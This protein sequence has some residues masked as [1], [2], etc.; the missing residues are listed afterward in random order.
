VILNRH[1][2]LLALLEATR[3]AAL[4]ARLQ[5]QVAQ[6]GFTRSIILGRAAQEKLF[7]QRIVELNPALTKAAGELLSATNAESARFAGILL[8]LRTSG[9]SPLVPTGVSKVGEF[10]RTTNP[11]NIHWGVHEAYLEADGSSRVQI[12]VG[13]LTPLQRR[14]ADLEWAQPKDRASCGATY[15]ETEAVQW[16]LKHPEDARVPEALYYTVRATFK[17]CRKDDQ[18]GK[19][20]LQAYNLLKE[21]YPNSEWAQK[22]KYWYK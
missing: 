22:T 19:I 2:P 11:G 14:Q 15:A 6:A 3:N 4:P 18:V 7:M 1:V 16:A 10:R 17:G 8:F 21:R 12:E 13:F 9:P 20:S 5:M